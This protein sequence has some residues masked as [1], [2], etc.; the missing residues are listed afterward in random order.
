MAR[1][2]KFDPRA[3]VANVTGGRPVKTYP[4]GET[5]YSQGDPTDAVF[6]VETGQLKATILSVRGKEAI[7]AMFGP[8]HFFGEGSLTGQPIRM[9][10][11]STVTPSVIARL[12]KDDVMKVIRDDPSFAEMFIAHLIGGVFAS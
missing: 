2:G 8:D 9:A 11:V 12:E 10:T 3:L 1:Q 5:I 6:Y 7:V 4:A